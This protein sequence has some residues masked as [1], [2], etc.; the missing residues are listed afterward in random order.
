VGEQGSGWRFEVEV[1]L[2][3]V[4]GQAGWD[5]DQVGGVGDVDPAVHTGWPPT[6]FETLYELGDLTSLVA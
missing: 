2:M 6:E 4:V 5:G 1:D 3:E